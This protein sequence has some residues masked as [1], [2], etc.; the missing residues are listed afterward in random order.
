[1]HESKSLKK[2]RNHQEKQIFTKVDIIGL[3]LLN[4]SSSSFY[5][6]S[7]LVLRKYYDR[8]HWLSYLAINDEDIF[9]YRD[10]IS[11]KNGEVTE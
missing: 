9:F 2:H 3:D 10:S 11:I 7:T 1:M 5:S 8:P 4:M 6:S